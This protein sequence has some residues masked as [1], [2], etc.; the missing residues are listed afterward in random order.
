MLEK[1]RISSYFGLQLILLYDKGKTEYPLSAYTN[2]SVLKRM[3]QVY[4]DSYVSTY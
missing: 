3:S 2:P 4:L 1:H